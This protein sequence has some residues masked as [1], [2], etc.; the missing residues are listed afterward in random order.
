MTILTGLPQHLYIFAAILALLLL[1]FLIFSLIPS[2]T[3]SRRLSRTIKG[4][5]SLNG[6]PDETLGQIFK[7]GDILEHLW[8]EYADSLHEQSIE[9]GGVR[10]RSTLPAGMVFRP[11]ILVDIPLRTDF[12]KHLPGLFT[13]VGIIGTFYGLLI[14]MKSFVVSDNSMVVRDS[15]TRLLHGVSE[16]F[17]ISASAITLAMVV[18]FIE[19]LLVTRLNAKV[20]RLAQLLD[21]LFEGG[22]GEEYLA[23]LVKASESSSVQTA[24][25]LKEELKE[26]FAELIEKQIAANTHSVVALGD[27]I[28]QS[29]EQGVSLPLAELSD[30]LKQDR[31]D[32][33]DALQALLK[34]VLDEFSARMAALF[35]GK[36]GEMHSLQQQVIAALQATVEKL[37]AVTVTAVAAGRRSTELMAEQLAKSNAAADSRQAAMQE[38]LGKFIEQMRV[39]LN[40]TQSDARA[41]LQSSLD[42]MSGRMAE[43][44]NALGEQVRSAT[45]ASARQQQDWQVQSKDIAGQF[46]GQLSNMV[47]GIA[48]AVGEMKSAVALMHSTASEAMAALSQSANTLQLASQ[49]FSHAGQAVAATLDKSAL[50]AGQLIQA[51]DSVAAA[52]GDLSEVFADYQSVRDALAEQ[53]HTLQL[54]AE[55]VQRDAS[56]SGEV[57]SKIESATGK[58]IAA[59]RD[60]DSYLEKISDVIGAAHQSFSEGMIRTVG[61]A[62]REFH[63]ALSDSVKLLREGIHELESTLD[64]VTSI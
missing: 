58:L 46:G 48:L 41:Q 44:V 64:A 38:I 15:L 37:E 25:L 34:S 60:A 62:N 21:G 33:A 14:G 50:V 17:L 59:H 55:Q 61:E 20:E 28:A 3:V 36:D 9:G 5:G 24:G 13:G 53:V 63:Q 4:L 57:M 30:S 31:K 43:V 22:A 19:K 39:V 23:R 35:G 52:S 16:A 2:F 1:S 27:R 11:D 47:E 6:K 49:D 10:L 42:D 29:I 45:D 12:F 26:I 51:S 8:H 56:M 7:D 18:T 32:Q 54:L 40:Q